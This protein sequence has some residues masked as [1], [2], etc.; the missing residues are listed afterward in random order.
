MCFQCVVLMS[1]AHSTKWNKNLLIWAWDTRLFMP[2]TTTMYC[3]ERTLLICSTIPFVVSLNTRFI[4]TKEKNF[5]QGIIALFVDIEIIELVW[6][7]WWLVWNE[8]ASENT[9]RN[10]GCVETSNS[11]NPR[12]VHFGLAFDEFILFGHMST[13]YSMSHVVLILYNLS[14]WKCMK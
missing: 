9:S 6:I 3:T 2:V 10:R 13:T 1:L 5:A 7:T 14:L 12:N 11:S 4:L 8:I